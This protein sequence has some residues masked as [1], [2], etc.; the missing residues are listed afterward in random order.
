MSEHLSCPA[1]LQI[2]RFLKGD[3]H[4]SQIKRGLDSSW[5]DTSVLGELVSGVSPIW[6]LIYEICFLFYSVPPVDHIRSLELDLYV[7][8]R[9]HIRDVFDL[10]TPLPFRMYIPRLLLSKIIE[11]RTRMYRRLG[12][13]TKLEAIR[14]MRWFQTDFY[15]AEDG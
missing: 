7:E 1:I 12:Y 14:R 11:V 8:N 10:R 5:V 15:W 9:H 6:G 3:Y 2:L 4:T 13:L